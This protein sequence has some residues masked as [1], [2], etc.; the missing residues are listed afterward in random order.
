MARFQDKVKHDLAL[1]G[2]QPDEV[3][4]NVMGIV[5]SFLTYIVFVI[6][7]PGFTAPKSSDLQGVV[8]EASV[9]KST[10]KLVTSFRGS[11][12]EFTAAAVNTVVRSPIVAITMIE[13]RG[14]LRPV[15]G[16][17][18]NSLIS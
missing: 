3:I 2:F 4:D 5:A 10:L 12:F 8:H 15:I 18:N 14:V 6:V 7:L 13:I 9:Y 1:F 11:G 16:I 17:I